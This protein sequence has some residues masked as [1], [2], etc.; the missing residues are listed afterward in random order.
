M[1][2][3]GIFIALNI[4]VKKKNKGLKLMALTSTRSSRIMEVEINPK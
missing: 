3:T 1:V 2:L 4:Y